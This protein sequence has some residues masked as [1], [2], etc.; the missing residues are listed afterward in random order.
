MS[1]KKQQNQSFLSAYKILCTK[2]TKQKYTVLR[3][4]YYSFQLGNM[5]DPKVLSF[6]LFEKVCCN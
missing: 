1:A 6:G 5:K 4:Q 2:L 3:N